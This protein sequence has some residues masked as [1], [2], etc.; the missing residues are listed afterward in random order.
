MQGIA[1]KHQGHN[2]RILEQSE[3]AERQSQAAG[4]GCG[5]FVQK[6]CDQYG[7][8]Y[9]KLGMWHAVSHD[10]DKNL[11]LCSTRPYNY[12][13]SSWSIFY[14]A[15]RAHF[16][17]FTS[18]E[19]PQQVP[20]P[21]VNH[22]KAIFDLGKKVIDVSLSPDARPSVAYENLQNHQREQVEADLI[23]AADGAMSNL[24]RRTVPKTNRPYSGYVAWRGTVPER[25]LSNH[26]T[27]TFQ[28]TS[29]CGL[30][31]GTYMVVWVTF[32]LA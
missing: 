3:K 18:S 17:G 16:D 30:E 26:T 9:T 7:I 29:L 13:V 15:L 22:G 5:P 14:H 6:F 10:L 11:N 28:T 27:D 20:P 12:F 4:I 1:L 8:D 2:V 31:R 25:Q 19:C 21:V 32:S 24:R 23:I